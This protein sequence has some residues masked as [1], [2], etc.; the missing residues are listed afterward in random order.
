[1]NAPKPVAETSTTS[2]AE[3]DSAVA[4]DTPAASDEEQL[5]V[6][7]QL[8]RLFDEDDDG[9]VTPQ[10][11][12]QKMNVDPDSEAMRRLLSFLDTDKNGSVS[13]VELRNCLSRLA[14]AGGEGLPPAALASPETFCS[15]LLGHVHQES[16]ATAES[17]AAH[18]TPTEHPADS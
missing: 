7:R 13:F 17:E 6:A 11:L 8:F 2:T 16:V 3:D 9:K 14:A 10:E 5:R 1:M 4:P 18:T 12:A 15:F